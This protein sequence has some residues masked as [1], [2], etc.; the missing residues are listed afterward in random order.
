MP[1]Q[2]FRAAL[3]ERYRL[4]LERRLVPAAHGCEP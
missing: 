3:E 1:L 2:S 4:T